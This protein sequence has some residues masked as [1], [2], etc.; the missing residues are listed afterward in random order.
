MDVETTAVVE[1][2]LAALR[3]YFEL[4]GAQMGLVPALAQLQRQLPG[5]V[6]RMCGTFANR[7]GS[8]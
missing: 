7:Q 5:Q 8:S 4:V 3:T 1:L 6:D 2:T